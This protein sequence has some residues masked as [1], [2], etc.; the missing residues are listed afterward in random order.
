MRSETILITGIGGQDG[1]YLAYNALK[2]G[3]KVI[4]ITSS[5]NQ[6]FFNLRYLDILKHVQ[7][8]EIRFNSL[9]K[10][11]NL[12]A[13]EGPST[14][15]NLASQSSVGLSFKNPKQTMEINYA[16][17][18][19]LIDVCF[20]VDE[21]IKIF[22]AS[23][24]E[25]FG[26]STNEKITEQDGYNPLSPYALSKVL[27]HETA[28]Y[29]RNILNRSISTGI[30]F[31]H[32]SVLRP[33]KFVIRKILNYLFNKNYKSHVLELGNIQIKRDW[34]YAPEY[35]Q[36]ILD[37]LNLEQCDDFIIS[38]G[39]MISL[40]QMI[41]NL[42]DE[43][44]LNYLDYVSIN[45]EFIRKNDIVQNC[46]D[47]RKLREMTGWN[48]KVHGRNLAKKLIEDEYAFR[49]FKLEQYGE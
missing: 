40:E 48:P 22:Q 10:L 12:I 27:A 19:K 32:E 28:I 37:I 31:N 47:N 29:H 45:S 41:Q 3:F 26:N 33:D 6:N 5:L 39:T 46:G 14:I 15:I 20:S 34:G 13:V 1:A 18:C 38:T 11:K 43:F 42:F 44:N 36:A 23:S 21:S 4:G 8:E 25:M 7:L 24:S 16:Y 30:M 2:R 35:T 49:K 9:E 17:F